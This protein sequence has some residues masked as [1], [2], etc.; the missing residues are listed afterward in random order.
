MRHLAGVGLPILEY[1]VPVYVKRALVKFVLTSV[2]YLWQRVLPQLAI[3]L[4]KDD[5]DKLLDFCL[6]VAFFHQQNFGYS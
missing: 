5:V 4:R 2:T 1:F 6:A 3:L